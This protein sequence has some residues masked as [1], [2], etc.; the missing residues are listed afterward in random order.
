MGS[1]YQVQLREKLNIC[2]NSEIIERGVFSH[3]GSEGLA[4][5]MTREFL[6]DM[7]SRIYILIVGARIASPRCQAKH[8]SQ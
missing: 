8:S 6:F 3:G 4:F 7:T 5:G 1:Y 2:W